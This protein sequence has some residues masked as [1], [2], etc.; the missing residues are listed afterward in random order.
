MNACDRFTFHVV[1]GH[2]YGRTSPVPSFKFGFFVCFVA[3][4]RSDSKI[5]DVICEHAFISIGHGHGGGI[6]V[7]LAQKW[8]SESHAC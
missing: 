7:S 1:S 2:S 5:G 4:G 8:M 3:D 6:G